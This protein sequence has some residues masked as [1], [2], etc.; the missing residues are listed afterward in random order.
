M[1]KTKKA[2]LGTGKR[3]RALVRIVRRKKLGPKKKKWAVGQSVQTVG[4]IPAEVPIRAP[5]TVTIEE[6]IHHP[7]TRRKDK[8]G[9]WEVSGQGTR[10]RVGYQGKSYWVDE[11]ILDSGE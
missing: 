8:F 7:G 4:K 11:D 1:K 10:I 6:V 2:K 5:A 3:F 9:D